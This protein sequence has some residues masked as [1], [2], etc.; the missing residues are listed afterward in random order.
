M[1]QEDLM[2][3]STAITNQIA[4]LLHML[5]IHQHL[6]CPSSPAQQSASGARICL[7]LFKKDLYLLTSSREGL[8]SLATLILMNATVLAIGAS[9]ALLPAED[10]IRLIPALLLAALLFSV[11]SFVEHGCAL[12]YRERAID[13]LRVIGVPPLSIF[14]SKV[15][16]ISLFVLGGAILSAS[17][18]A[19]L[20]NV[21]LFGAWF[22]LMV[23]AGLLSLGFSSLLVLLATIT[24][25]ARLQGILLPLLAIPLSFPL[26]L[27]GIELPLE[28]LIGGGIWES[29]WLP[30]LIVADVVYFIG[31]GNLYDFAVK[32]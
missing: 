15:A 17:T 14:I 26:I 28:A 6:H 20:L 8:T 30:L 18:I 2:R 23:C 19:L 9:S 5:P 24:I 3:P 27:A 29:S 32:A 1:R 25:N 12:D 22:Q 4:K 31:G 16:A 10:I 11:L 7:L 21:S 13:A